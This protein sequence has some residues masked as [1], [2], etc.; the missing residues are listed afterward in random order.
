VAVGVRERRG[1]GSKLIRAVRRAT[2]SDGDGGQGAEE[3]LRGLVLNHVRFG[4]AISRACSS[5]FTWN[6]S[7][8]KA[9]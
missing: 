8:I 3:A 1:L 5:R 2:S 9:H 6:R 4:R 7:S